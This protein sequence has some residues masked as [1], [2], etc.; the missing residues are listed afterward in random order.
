[1]ASASA[2]LALV[3]AEIAHLKREAAA[4]SLTAMSAAAEAAKVAAAH[5]TM[6]GG[7][8]A[9]AAAAA[10]PKSPTGR[11]PPPSYRVLSSG[12]EVADGVDYRAAE[13]AT[14]VGRHKAVQRRSLLA[15]VR[16]LTRVLA[17]RAAT[18]F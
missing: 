6:T 11:P 18:A 9:A 1:M 5:A 8:S 12:C 17:R 14:E 3:D 13:G 7:A 16:V 10:A 15:C 2:Q 4:E